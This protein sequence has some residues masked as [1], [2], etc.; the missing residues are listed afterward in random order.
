MNEKSYSLW[1]WNKLPIWGPVISQP[2]FWEFDKMNYKL[3][4]VP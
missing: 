1:E 2:I 4:R 3:D